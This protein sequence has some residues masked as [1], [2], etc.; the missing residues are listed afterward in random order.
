MSEGS[1]DSGSGGIG[2]FGGFDNVR[3]EIEPHGPRSGGEHWRE[4]EGPS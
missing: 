2:G 1:G 3:A 4:G